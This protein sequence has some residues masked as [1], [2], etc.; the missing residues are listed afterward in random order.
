MAGMQIALVARLVGVVRHGV[1]VV[2]HGPPEVTD[3]PVLIVHRFELRGM[4]TAEED[5]A[6]AKKGL[7]VVLAVP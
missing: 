7:N 1:R 6:T 2:L 5:R 4:G 3:E